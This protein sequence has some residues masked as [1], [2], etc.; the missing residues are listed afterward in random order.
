MLEV[1]LGV[2]SRG[3]LVFVSVDVGWKLEAR[4]PC[5]PM[6]MCTLRLPGGHLACH[7][8]AA[9]THSHSNSGCLAPADPDLQGGKEHA[10]AAQ[11]TGEVD[12]GGG[13]GGGA[14]HRGLP[15]CLRGPVSA[16]SPWFNAPQERAEYL[17][18]CSSSTGLDLFMQAILS[19]AALVAE[20]GPMLFTC[21]LPEEF[22]VAVPLRLTPEEVRQPG[23]RSGGALGRGSKGGRGEGASCLGAWCTRPLL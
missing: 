2:R 17:S 1:H 15:A 14:A 10:A 3:G 5:A 11:C 23:L 16:R 4:L 12:G 9:P 13:R 19:N 22:L 18:S 7:R 20:S 21:Q 6:C 8:Q